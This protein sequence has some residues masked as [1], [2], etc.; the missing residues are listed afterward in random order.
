LAASGITGVLG[1]QHIGIA[2]K[3]FN[4]FWSLWWRPN[5]EYVFQI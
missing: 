4:R 2:V 1:V 5:W 3:W